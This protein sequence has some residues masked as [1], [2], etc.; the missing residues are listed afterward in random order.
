MIQKSAEVH[1]PEIDVLTEGWL[2]K[3]M[4]MFHTPSQWPGWAVISLAVGLAALGTV[5]W[6]LLSNG[7]MLAWSIFLIQSV[8]S[9]LDVIMLQQLPRKQLSYGP[10]KSQLMALT[11][12]RTL[13]S[14]VMGGMAMLIE[15]PTVLTTM[16]VLQLVGTAAFYWGAYIEPFRLRL[17]EFL[18]FTDR[19]PNGL[20]RIRILHIT[21]LHI[22]KW[23]QR[24]ERV[25][26]IVAETKPDLIVI[27][28]DY[29]N[30]SYNE[31]PETHALVHR[32]LSQLEAPYGVYATLGS[33]PVDL[34][35]QIVPIFDELDIPLMRQEWRTIDFGDGRKLVLMGM[36]CTH[37]LPTD[38]V[39]LAH[40]ASQAPA[41]LPQVL[42]MHS[43]EIM[44]LAA[45]SGID[46][47]LCGHT[48]GGQVRLPII[49]PLLTSS[50][51]GRRF[52]MGHYRLGRT[53][54]YVSRGIGLEGMSAPRVR[55]MAPPEITLV[56]MVPGGPEKKPA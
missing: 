27:T 33:P 8:F 18:M 17:T 26:E 40:L 25:L 48:H 24:E 50:Q 42:L 12:P 5:S 53:H 46:L 35:E 28:G 51:L 55:F 34:R 56:T 23:T 39:R 43:P 38:E 7:R 11:V 49:G 4:V 54:L 15:V 32:L 45:R 29:V 6:R 14:M 20:P 52:V 37:H 22:E 47:Y 2:H 9:L 16:I 10:W 13:A 36:D 1:D 30:L 3:V 31:D 44:P 19:L 41:D 21:D